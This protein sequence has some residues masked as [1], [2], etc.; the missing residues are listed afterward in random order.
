MAELKARMAQ[1]DSKA[2]ADKKKAAG[3]PSVSIGGRILA[4]TATFDQ[5][6]NSVTQVGDI[7]NGTEMRSTRL[8]IKGAMFDVVDFKLGVRPGWPGPSYKDVYMAVKELPSLGNLRVGHFKEPFGM[9]QLIS[10][11]YTTFMERASG[12]A[13]VFVPARNMGIMGSRLQ[14]ERANHLGY[15]WI[16]QRAG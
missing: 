10:S 2:A 11:R 1:I 7:E 14:Q 16:R 12:D 3:Q 8:F 9:E 15:R 6:A 5:N 13:G 4:D